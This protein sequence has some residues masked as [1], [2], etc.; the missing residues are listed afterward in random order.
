VKTGINGYSLARILESGENGYLHPRDQGHHDL[1]NFRLQNFVLLRVPL[2]P[3]PKLWRRPFPLLQQ[4]RPVV[5]G[6]GHVDIAGE[7]KFKFIEAVH[8]KQGD[9]FV[10]RGG[11]H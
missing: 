11:M 1:E 7:Q 9:I 6:R 2:P 8:L 4:N 3:A 5:T 10:Q